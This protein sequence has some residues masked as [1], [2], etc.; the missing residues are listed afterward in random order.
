[1]KAQA[2]QNPAILIV[3]DDPIVRE[4]LSRLLSREGYDLSIAV[5]GT[6]AL[7]KAPEITPDLI[8]L[9]VMMPG[10]DGF[11]VCRRLR[12]APLLVKVPIIM[13]TGLDD[14]DSRLT[15]LQ[16]GAD[17]FIAKP[18]DWTELRARVRTITG[19]SQHRRLRTLELQAER[20]RTRSILEALGEAVVVTDLDGIIEYVNPATVH[21]TGY[22]SQEAIGQRWSL[23]QRDQD[24]DDLYARIRETIHG[25][26]TWRSEVVNQRKDGTL[27]DAI[28]TVA[29]LFYPQRTGSPSGFVSV[30]QD[31]TPLKEAERLK[32][33]FVSNVSHEL[34][35]P[36]SVLTLLA[37]NL[38]TLYERLDDTRRRKMVRDIQKH[39][40]ILND[41]IDDVLE[42][43]RLD[44]K[45]ISRERRQVNLAG[46]VR[47]EIERQLPLA[48]ERNQDCRAV[49]GRR[50][51]VCGD[52]TQLQ[53]VIRNL[54]NNAIKYTPDGGQITCEYTAYTPRVEDPTW[55]GSRDL[56]NERWAALRVSDTGIG[57]AHTDIPHL[58]ERFYRVKTQSNVRGTG[59]GLAIARELIELHAGHISVASTPGHGSVF[60]VYLPLSEE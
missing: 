47:D 40:Q 35:T 28:L 50:L 25:G 34:S 19:L 51:M 24:T 1:M 13:L 16:A 20:D 59:L 48:H 31:I 58:F 43:S 54:V 21:L 36:L 9:D 29:P 11:E 38:N 18:V 26:E 60:A 7:D 22:S 37:E 4:T 52:K 56:P 15:G 39:T 49:G 45:R 55:P 6:E 42:I 32:D 14:R 3:D 10:M 44:S 41:L 5:N 2:D 53:R 8:L 33:R 46:L 30:Q 17:D 23:W 12:A 57:I 27:Y